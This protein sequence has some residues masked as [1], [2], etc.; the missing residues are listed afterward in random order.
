MRTT[1]NDVSLLPLHRVIQMILI[2]DDV[3][4]SSETEKGSNVY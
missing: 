3:M 2:Q 1:N 4:V